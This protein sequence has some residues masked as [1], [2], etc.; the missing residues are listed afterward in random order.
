MALPWRPTVGAPVVLAPVTK[1]ACAAC[2]QQRSG[3]VVAIATAGVTVQLGD[4]TH[5]T[6][7]ERNVRSAHHPSATATAPTPRGTPPARR[8]AIDPRHGT[9]TTIFDFLDEV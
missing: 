1:T 7:H 4:G 9:E 3:V 8:S 2:Y 5:V 6:T